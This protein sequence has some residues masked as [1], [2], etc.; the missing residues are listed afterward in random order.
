MKLSESTAC[1]ALPGV[2][3][4]RMDSID[5]ETLAIQS[6]GDVEV[7]AGTLLI[8]RKT[9]ERYFRK[10]WGQPPA[11]WAKRKLLEKAMSLICQGYS[12]KAIVID[13]HMCNES[14]FCREFRKMFGAA[15]G[16]FRTCMASHVAIRSF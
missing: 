1:P 9:I 10:K 16:N 5:W 12:V 15:P 6:R 8:S 14:W 4:A 11:R 2:V 7:M 13:L 3:A